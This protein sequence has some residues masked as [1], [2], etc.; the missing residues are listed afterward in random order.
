MIFGNKLTLRWL[1]FFFKEL[2]CHKNMQFII[3]GI[4]LLAI[5]QCYSYNARD[6]DDIQNFHG[7]VIG[8][9][10]FFCHHDSHPYI[11]MS[12]FDTNN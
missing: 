6:V 2:P 1:Y 4:P 5:I 10:V 12:I 11:S 7:L 9:I 8:D 3:I